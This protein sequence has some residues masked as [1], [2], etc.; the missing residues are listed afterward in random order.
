[1]MAWG[2]DFVEYFRNSGSPVFQKLANLMQIG[3]STFD[4]L[5]AALT[6]R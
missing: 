4:G 6:K 1:M 3:V 2:A 5:N